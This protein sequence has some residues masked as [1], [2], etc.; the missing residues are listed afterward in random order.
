MQSLPTSEAYGSNPVNGIEHFFRV[1]CIEKMK[2][3]KKEFGNG[4]RKQ[5]EFAKKRSKQK[6]FQN[7]CDLSYLCIK[8]KL[9]YLELNVDSK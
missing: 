9:S 6:F 3:K 4:P 1:K 8:T 7:K 5:R 2:M